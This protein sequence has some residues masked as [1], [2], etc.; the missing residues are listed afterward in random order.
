M[1]NGDSSSTDRDT[2]RSERAWD[3]PLAFEKCGTATRDFWARLWLAQTRQ[4]SEETR[5]AIAERPLKSI[6][7]QIFADERRLAPR[8]LQGTTTRIPDTENCRSQ[9]VH[10]GLGCRSSRSALFL[11][12]SAAKSVLQFASTDPISSSPEYREEP[13][14]GLLAGHRGKAASR[15]LFWVTA[16]TALDRRTGVAHVPSPLSRARLCD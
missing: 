5:L 13:K 7:P 14:R 6:L 1:G 3:S 16:G 4:W 8:D 10:A 15:P 2:R 11:R 9:R 12:K